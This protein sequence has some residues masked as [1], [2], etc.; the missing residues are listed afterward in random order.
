MNASVLPPQEWTSSQK[1]APGAARVPRRAYHPMDPG[2]RRL[3][4]T[5]KENPWW[6]FTI[7]ELAAMT[8]YS[9]DAISAA[10]EYGA[11]F[12]FGK[13]RPEWVMEWMAAHPRASL[14]NP[15]GEEPPRAERR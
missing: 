3:I 11:R 5:A 13:S 6:T 4:A 9:R 1:T 7:E 12:P 15:L 8:G 10:K 2:V 14:K